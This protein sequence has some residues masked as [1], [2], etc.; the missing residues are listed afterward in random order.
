VNN[1]VSEGDDYLRSQKNKVRSFLPTSQMLSSMNLKK[2]RNRITFK[3]FTRV[4]GKQQVRGI[5]F[6]SSI[7]F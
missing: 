6:I 5:N 7:A 1:L 4:L 2:G 3:F